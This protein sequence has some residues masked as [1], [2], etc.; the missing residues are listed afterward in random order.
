MMFSNQLAG[1]GREKRTAGTWLV[2]LALA[3]GSA[4]MQGCATPASSVNMVAKV[5]TRAPREALLKEGITVRNVTGG[6]DTNPLWMS[7]VSNDD[8]KK[9]LEDSLQSAR[10]H[11]GGVPA[12]YQLDATLLKLD[13]PMFGLDLT[14]T[15][16]TQY[17]LLETGSGNRVFTR[18]IT[19]PFTARVSDS[20]LAIERLRIANEGA[21]RENI[22]HFLREILDLDFA[23]TATATPPAR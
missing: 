21:V 12:R 22:Q 20:F 11:N 14:V 16:S 1:V 9:A 7:K 23:R 4:L 2:A 8:F 17:D 18:T 15:C 10:L 6:S 13:Q 19:T 3:F 5:D